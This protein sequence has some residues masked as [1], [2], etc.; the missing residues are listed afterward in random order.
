MICGQCGA[1]VNDNCEFCPECGASLVLDNS[2]STISVACTFCGAKIPVYTQYCP[3][4]GAQQHK[5]SRRSQTSGGNS[6]GSAGG[7]SGGSTGGSSGGSTGGSSGGS[8]GGPSGGSTG[9]P[10]GGSMGGPSGGSM[11]GPSGGSAGG[12]SGGSMGGP[13]GV[14][15]GGTMYPPPPPPPKKNHLGLIVGIILSLLVVAGALLAYFKYFAYPLIDLNEYAQVTLKGKDGEGTA[16][17]VFNETEF[18]NDWKGKIVY[19]GNKEYIKNVSLRDEDG[20]VIFYTACVH[21]DFD[22]SSNLSNGDVITFK[23]RFDDNNARK[24]YKIRVSHE[25]F[26]VK[27]SGLKE[28]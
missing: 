17:M 25:E 16:T 21:G 27:V 9:G 7:S 6:G 10:S 3:E 28:S 5:K 19:S 11:G 4:C 15:Y 1:T 2:P 24:N 8:T 20:A 22:K 13:S 23:W 14:S 26:N 12:S 18:Y